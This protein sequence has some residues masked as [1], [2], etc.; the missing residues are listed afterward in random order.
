M[1]PVMVMLG[2]R[3][4]LVGGINVLTGDIEV[5]LFALIGKELPGMG[6]RAAEVTQTVE[7]TVGAM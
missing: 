5:R 1:I 3:L 2:E 7:V 4:D 6:V